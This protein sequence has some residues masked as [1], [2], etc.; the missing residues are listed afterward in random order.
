MTATEDEHAANGNAHVHADG[1]HEEHLVPC[2]TLIPHRHTKV[3]HLIRHGLGFHNVAGQK[4]H[5][6]YKSWEFED[7]HLTAEGWAQALA[8]GQHIRSLG[9]TFRADAVVISPLTRALETAAGAFGVGPWQRSDPQPPFM[10]EQTDV[11]GKR[12]EMHAISAAGCPPLIAWEGCREHLGV[13]P[14]DKRRP[15]REV[16]PCFPAVDFSLVEDEEDVL[17]R[18]EHRETHEEIRRRGVRFLQWLMSRPEQHIAVVSH[19]S[20]FFFM[21]QAFGHGAAPR[22][23][24][25]LHKW[26][27]NC[28]LRT[29]V[30]SDEGGAHD[31]PDPLHFRGGKHVA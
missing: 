25:E 7:A 26:Y 20:F 11:P 13:H 21:L 18:L 31:H 9:P 4:D 6:Q 24:G 23:Q 10:V 27:D 5:D 15:L 19:S 22:V 14:C 3:V 17:W 30:L 2:L 1:S 28:E 29:V 16:K 8:L 12:A